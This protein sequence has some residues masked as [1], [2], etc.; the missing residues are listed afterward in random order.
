M[1]SSRHPIKYD[2]SELLNDIISAL[3]G[4]KKQRF[5]ADMQAYSNEILQ[6]KREIAEQIVLWYSGLSMANGANP[7]LGLDIAADIGI[8]T[9]LTR[10]IVLIYGLTS[11]SVE[12]IQHFLKKA[13]PVLLTKIA[14]FSARYLGGKIVSNVAGKQAAKQAATQV[15]KQTVTGAAKQTATRVSKWLGS[16]LS[17]Q[18][19]TKVASQSAAKA[20]SRTTVKW[21]PF[22]GPVIAGAIGGTSTFIFGKQIINDSEQLAKEILEEL[23][24]E[25]SKN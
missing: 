5:I 19:A 16:K 14:Q 25:H 7:I 15:S 24:Q 10:R 9:D 13:P 12:Y 8:F 6:Q 21:V 22:V 11:E 20:A 4:V 2:F 1:I 17:K 18:A 3:S 23:I